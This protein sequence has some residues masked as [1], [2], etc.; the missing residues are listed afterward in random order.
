MLGSP[1]RMA[2]GAAA[3]LIVSTPVL[4][5]R[6][7]LPLAAVSGQVPAVSPSQPPARRLSL[8]EAVRLAL[9][10]NLQIKIAR[11]DPQIQDVAV[12]QARASW[13]PALSTTFTRNAQSQPAQSAIVPTS[14][15]ATFATGVGVAQTLPW[16]GHYSVDWNNERQTTTN[17][18]SDFSPLLLSTTNLS[19][20]QPLLRNFSIDQIREQLA[21]SQKRR[22]LSDIDVRGVVAEI[23]RRVESAYWDLVYA[24]DNVA[25]QRQ[26]LDLSR[27]S[28]G[29]NQ[30][31]VA[32][33][34]MARVDIV[35]DEAEVA[36]NQQN[37]II[38]EGAVASARNRLRALIFDPS[39]PDV[40]SIALEPSDAAPFDDRPVDVTA[41]VAR[42]LQDRTDLQQARNAVDQNA[43]AL[44]FSRNQILPDVSLVLNYGTFGVG[45]TELTPVDLSSASN[46]LPSSRSIVSERGYGS[47]L[48]D[49]LASVYPQWTIGVQIGYQLSTSAARANLARAQLEADQTQLRVKDLEMQATLQ[50]REAAQQVE[51]SQKRVVAARASTALQR[52]K[53]EAEQRKVAAGTSVP[54]FVIQAE[55]DLAQAQTLE[56]RALLDYEKARVDFDAI[57]EVPL[58]G[59]ADTTAADTLPVTAGIRR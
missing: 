17:I 23:S 58:P 38:A 43:V 1:L 34:T 11:L 15:N 7:P 36:A 49:V 18:L 39:T 37:V 19:Y 52:E 20:T 31:R 12:A 14:Q 53:L 30:Q 57:Q 47:V 59:V 35:Q 9:E 25:V 50:V 51:T 13:S 46:V 41:A 22:D 3:V 28:L 24:N 55:R 54:F 10:Q 5:Q 6:G 44:R 56:T 29:E 4:A 8:D 26:A 27:Q 42:A 2:A 48:G 33:G 21:I 40:W 16:G 32:N 45:G